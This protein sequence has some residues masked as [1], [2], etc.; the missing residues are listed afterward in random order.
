MTKRITYAITTN[1]LLLLNRD[2]S[3]MNLLIIGG[4]GYIGSHMVKRLLVSKHSITIIDNLSTG[5]RDAL[6]SGEFIL[7]DIGDR[8]F[9]DKV[10][11]EHKFDAVLHFASFIQVGESVKKPDIYY[12][13]I[14]R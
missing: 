14:S 13:H 2:K 9:L 1:L 6:P 3:F 7:G 12:Q 5:Y 8:V 4:A 10:F 11:S